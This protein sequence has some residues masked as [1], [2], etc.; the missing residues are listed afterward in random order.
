M[1]KKEPERSSPDSHAALKIRHLSRRSYVNKSMCD[2]SE[3]VFTLDEAIEHAQSYVDDSPCGQNHRQLAEWLMELDRLKTT[4]IGNIYLLRQALVKAHTMLKVC[5]WP[6]G[7]YMKGV[8]DLMKE[9][10]SAIDAPARNCDVGTV[11][12]QKV[13]FLEFCDVVKGPQGH[14]RNCRVCNASDCELAW[15]QMPYEKG[16]AE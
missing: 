14:C 12:D 13:R 4:P 16:D 3:K 15:A 11:D 10:E 5:D 8:A 9:I 1:K 2:V 6:E 7:V